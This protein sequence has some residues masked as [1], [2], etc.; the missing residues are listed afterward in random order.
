M[1]K[2]SKDSNGSSSPFL[3]RDIQAN[4]L[5]GSRSAPLFRSSTTVSNTNTNNDDN[6]D[7]PAYS[8][9]SNSNGIELHDVD[10]GAQAVRDE[11]GRV[12]ISLDTKGSLLTKITSYLHE[13]PPTYEPYTI[14]TDM[15]PAPYMNIV[16]H[17]VGSRGD[18]QP[19][20]ALARVLKEVHG[21][22][23]RL[24]THPKFESFVEKAGI[25][26]FSIGGDPA[27]L[28]DYMVKNAGLMPSAEALLNG[29]VRRKRQFMG[30]IA[31]GCWRS[32]IEPC[33]KT[34]RPFVADAIIANPPSFA[35]VHCAERLAVPLHL[36]FTYVLIWGLLFSRREDER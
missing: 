18:V 35:H 8:V 9:T 22:R 2:M 11:D 12:S 33:A 26:F 24:A 31:E 19:F 6:N 30:E 36:M 5:A 34:G 17:V 14:A 28:M 3:R 20:L 32:C 13:E 25:E 15:G 29:D 16:I 10:F 23:V 1:H 7:L 27:E 4:S 21:H